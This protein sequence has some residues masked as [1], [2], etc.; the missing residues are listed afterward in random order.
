[1]K[2]GRSEQWLLLAV[3][4]IA[5]GWVSMLVYARLTAPPP[6]I[7]A[8]DSAVDAGAS[9]ATTKD[10]GQ[11]E[12]VFSAADLAATARPEGA[13]AAPATDAPSTE[14]PGTVSASTGPAPER[15][16]D[17]LVVSDPIGARVMDTVTTLGRT[18]I[19]FARP[20]TPAD[21]RY[22]VVQKTGFR[23]VRISI[24]PTSSQRIAVTLEPR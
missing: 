22:L 15:S 11:A 7:A 6:S 2:L 3:M 8:R 1:V 17:I 9:P 20:A 10:A 19:R 4:L 16:L 24:T 21:A 14:A 12:M 13:T 18:P 5:A 23:S